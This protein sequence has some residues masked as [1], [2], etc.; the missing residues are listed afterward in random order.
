MKFEVRSID[1]NVKFAKYALRDIDKFYG[2]NLQYT[3]QILHSLV[4]NHL[5]MLVISIVLGLRYAITTFSS[6]A[7]AQ[8]KIRIYASNHNYDEN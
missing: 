4:E 3:A 2:T 7:D 5:V 1:G 8:I 6:Y